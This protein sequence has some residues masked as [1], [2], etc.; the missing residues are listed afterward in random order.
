MH[1]L[2][3]VFEKPDLMYSIY[4]CV[5]P[6]NVS[7]SMDSQEKIVKAHRSLEVQCVFQPPLKH[8]KHPLIEVSSCSK[9]HLPVM[10]HP[11]YTDF[12]DTI[13]RFKFN[14]IKF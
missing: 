2:K 1:T 3:A 5:C 12:D 4:S 7:T 8:P 10:T 11:L 9:V 13:F 6:E 14:N